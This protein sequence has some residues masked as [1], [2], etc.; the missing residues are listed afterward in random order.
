MIRRPPRSTL[1]SSS[2]ASDVY[3]RQVS[4]QSTGYGLTTMVMRLIL[5]VGLAMAAFSADLSP[6]TD[7]IEMIQERADDGT[8][9]CRF[10]RV[11]SITDA[12][13]QWW[14]LRELELYNSADGSGEKLA[15]LKA[16]AS[17]FKGLKIDGPNDD[18]WLPEKAI[19][20]N[21]DTFWSS[22]DRYKFEWIGVEFQDPVDVRSIKMKTT[23]EFRGPAMVIVEK[24]SDGQWWSRS[25]EVSQMGDWGSKM[26]TYPLINMDTVPKSLFALRSQQNPRFCVGVRPTPHP[27]DDKAEPYPLAEDAQLEVQVCDGNKNTQYFQLTADPTPMLRNAADQSFV[28]HVNGAAAEGTP[29]TMKQCKEGCEQDSEFQN[30]VFDF[31]AEEFGGLMRDKEKP[32]LVFFPTDN[33]LVEGKDIILQA[34]GPSDETATI[35]ACAGQALARWEL[36]PMFVIEPGKETVSCAPYSHDNLEPEAATTREQAQA[37][38]A[39]DNECTAY[40]WVSDANT[41]EGDTRTNLVYACTDMH[42]VHSGVTGWELGVRAGRLEPFA[43]EQ[44]NQQER[45]WTLYADA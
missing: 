37:V 4:T 26:T 39:K 23:G 42:E 18:Q 13:D 40:N 35:E 10:W 11:R 45:T 21:E 34:C 1:S 6:V 20:G 9:G 19:D 32:N 15:P 29:L 12:P 25:T 41:A 28:V 14:Q 2:A 43:E 24:S 33:A 3:K 5:L 7:S 38:C 17:S 22:S 8:I 27:S 31:A 36:L 16:I 30:D 44:T